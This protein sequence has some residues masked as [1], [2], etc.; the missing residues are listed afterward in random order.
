MKLFF[1][2]E[3]YFPAQW[4]A[5]RFRVR[6]ANNVARWAEWLNTLEEAEE[7]AERA[8]KDAGEHKAG[9]L[10]NARKP[11]N[12]CSTFRITDHLGAIHWPEETGF[13]G[14]AFR[15]AAPWREGKAREENRD[16][17]CAICGEAIE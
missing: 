15:T 14:N 16:E 7:H 3:Y 9:K 11:W 10:W 2:V 8:K 12:A 6:D 17:Y 13:A 4:N 1:R 5:L